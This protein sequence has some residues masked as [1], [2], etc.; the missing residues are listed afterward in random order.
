MQYSFLISLKAFLLFTFKMLSNL[1]FPSV[2]KLKDRINDTSNSRWHLFFFL[3]STSQKSKFEVNF[4]I[5][6][7]AIL[8]FLALFL[9]WIVF[10]YSYLETFTTTYLFFLQMIRSRIKDNKVSRKS[11]Q[12][13]D[14]FVNK[15]TWKWK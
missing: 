3:K 9:F 4:L 14:L 5:R 15:N 13:R 11:T 6:D 12:N 8:N 7:I 1:K 10:C 2:R